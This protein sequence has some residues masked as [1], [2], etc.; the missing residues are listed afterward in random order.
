M[1]KKKL[2]PDLLAKMASRAQKSEQYLRE[3]VSRRAGRLGVSSLAAQLLWAR[4]LGLGITAA[5]NR[6]DSSVRDEVR[7]GPAGSPSVTHSSPKRQTGPTQRRKETNL[8][9]A[10]INFLLED[11]ELKDRCRD[12]ILAKKHYDRVLREAT[13]VLDDRLKKV[14]GIFNLNPSPLVGKALSP[15]PAK[16][17]IVVSAEKDEQEGF[18]Y[19]C[20]GVMQAFRNK[21]HH[22][23]SGAFTQADAFKFCG[24]V[25]TILAVI[26]EGKVHPERV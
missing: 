2:D 17:V 26:A 20:K 3:Q 16:A 7:S 19:I 9:A 14:S 5:L 18:F 12:L 13:T 10:T 22:N 11:A 6:A 24:F 25:D 8:G 4:E 23:L 1:A 21:T 15:D